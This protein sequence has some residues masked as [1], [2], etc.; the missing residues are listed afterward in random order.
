M[1]APKVTIILNYTNASHVLCGDALKDVY[2]DFRMKVLRPAEWASWHSHLIAAS[3]FTK[4]WCI[5]KAN[6]GTLETALLTHNIPYDM[7]VQEVDPLAP[8]YSKN[9][10][11]AV[12]PTYKVM[13]TKAIQEQK[14]RSG[15]SRYAIKKYILANFRVHEKTLASNLNRG[16][17]KMVSRGQLIQA[18]PNNGRFKL[19]PNFKKELKSRPRKSKPFQAPPKIKLVVTD[20]SNSQRTIIECDNQEILYEQVKSL[21]EV[22]WEYSDPILAIGEMSTSGYW[23][24]WGK[25]PVSIH[26]E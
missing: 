14:D 16:L 7:K 24:G 17:K 9:R 18:S 12:H 19:S 1:S 13:I 10:K 15:P 3:P 22:Y 20:K 6:L 8:R 26:L 11:I 2:A 21:G 4:G 5:K 23:D 25:S